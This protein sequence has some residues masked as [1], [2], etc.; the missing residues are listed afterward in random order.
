MRVFVFEGWGRGDD[1][2]FLPAA[3]HPGVFAA[4]KKINEA[5][6]VCVKDDE[7]LEPLD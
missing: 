2:A 7:L 4:L 3:K 1:C 6:F 5:H